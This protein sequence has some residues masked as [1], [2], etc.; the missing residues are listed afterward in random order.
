MKF[1]SVKPVVG[2]PMD[3]S[4]PISGPHPSHEW[5]HR[6]IEPDGRIIAVETYFKSQDFKDRYKQYLAA[7][8][9]K[10]LEV[11]KPVYVGTLTK[12][13]GIKG[14]TKA[15]V[16]HP[17]FEFGGKY[18]LTIYSETTNEPLVV[19]FYKETLDPQIQKV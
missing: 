11:E 15:E 17:V 14:Y 8:P 9:D 5:I 1:N 2:I 10:E 12:P 4:K 19:P 18:T 16:G 7:Q 3:A 6:V 13:F